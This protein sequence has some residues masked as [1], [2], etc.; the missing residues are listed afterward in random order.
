MIF[1][2]V[3]ITIF[4]P[5]VTSFDGSPYV[6]AHNFRMAKFLGDAVFSTDIPGP[7]FLEFM[8]NQHRVIRLRCISSRE[9]NILQVP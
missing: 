3:K 4:D 1:K 8:G 2:S 6:L 9:L 5:K 7:C